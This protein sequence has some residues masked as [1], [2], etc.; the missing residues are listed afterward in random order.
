MERGHFETSCDESDGSLGEASASTA[1]TLPPIRIAV[2]VSQARPGMSRPEPR[3]LLIDLRADVHVP[4]D[5]PHCRGGG[6]DPLPLVRELIDGRADELRVAS[7][8]GRATH[9]SNGRGARCDTMFCV[10]LSADT[11]YWSRSP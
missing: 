6:F 8:E 3:Q 10:R 5:N 2:L 4:C 7:C 11:D 1:R 9:A